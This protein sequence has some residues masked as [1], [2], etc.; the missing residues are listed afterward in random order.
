MGRSW[1]AWLVPGLLAAS[2]IYAIY[3][4]IRVGDLELELA[5]LERAKAS[6]DGPPAASAPKAEVPVPEQDSKLLDRVDA[7]EDDLADLQENYANL[8]E[9]L[10]GTK[11]PGTNEARILDVVTRAQ[12]RVLDRQLEFHSA[13]W[14]K[15]REA[16]VADFAVKQKLDSWQ[17]ERIRKLLE[18]E[19]DEML[20][21]ITRPGNA[22]NP[23]KTAAEFQ[24][25]LDRTDSEAVGLLKEDQALAWAL[26]R[27]FER[28]VL[29]PWLPS[30]QPKAP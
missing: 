27:Q 15:T 26:N 14:R 24:S 4:G 13:Q 28:R 10:A 29:W 3:L 5:Q 30:L 9:K 18:Q 21:I 16:A 12:S 11:D 8:D 23:E 2:V 17:T 22:E 25:A 20:E 19:I 6:K 7:I 1:I